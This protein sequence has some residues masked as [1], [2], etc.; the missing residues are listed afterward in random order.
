MAWFGFSIDTNL[1][2]EQFGQSEQ[3]RPEPVRRT[4][5]PVTTMTHNSTSATIAR[6]WNVRAETV[7]RS[8]LDSVEPT[9]GPKG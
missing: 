7:N 4:A 5:A 2:G 6:T 3:P 9:I 8:S 1:S